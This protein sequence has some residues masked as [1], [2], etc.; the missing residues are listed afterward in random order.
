MTA[1]D[2]PAALPARLTVGLAARLLPTPAD[3]RRYQAEF[4]AELHGLTPAAQLRYAVGVLSQTFA[5]RAAL[6]STATRLVEAEMSSIGQR[7][8]CRV[9]RW[10]DWHLHSAEDGTRYLSCSVCGKDH[11]GRRGMDNTIGA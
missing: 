6:G 9:L 4:V 3:R 11:P 1:P 7:F 5:L 10:H 8:R 2:P